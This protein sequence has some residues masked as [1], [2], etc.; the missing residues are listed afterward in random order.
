MRGFK[1][2]NV[3]PIVGDIFFSVTPDQFGKNL[4]KFRRE[5]ERRLFENMCRK[6]TET[7]VGSSSYSGKSADL[8]RA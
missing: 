6:V 1:P 7:T 5:K 4:R 2:F 3:P 8:E